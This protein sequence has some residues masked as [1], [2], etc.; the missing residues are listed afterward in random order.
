[1]SQATVNLKVAANN[2]DII[3]GFQTDELMEQILQSNNLNKAYEE[4]I[5]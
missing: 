3:T 5:K 4:F 2:N 1:M